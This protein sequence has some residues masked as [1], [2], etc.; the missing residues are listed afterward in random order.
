MSSAPDKVTD[1]LLAFREETGDFGT[2]LYAGM[3]WQDK[4]L[5]S[6]RCS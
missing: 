6:A 2:L 3:D 1:E 5:P 4:A